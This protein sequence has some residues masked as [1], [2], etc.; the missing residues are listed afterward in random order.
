MNILISRNNRVKFPPQ[1]LYNSLSLSLLSFHPFILNFHSF[2][3][4]PFKTVSTRIFQDLSLLMV[5]LHD[6][7]PLKN[8][9]IRT[10]YYDI[11]FVVKGLSYFIHSSLNFDR[12]N[13]HEDRWKLIASFQTSLILSIQFVIHNWIVIS[14]DGTHAKE[15]SIPSSNN[16]L[17]RIFY[18]GSIYPN[19]TNYQNYDTPSLI[20]DT[21][22]YNPNT[23]THRI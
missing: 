22:V 11:Q 1:F 18:F 12:V 9:S 5:K 8:D 15:K 3:S 17:E 10:M 23:H 2:H 4:R 13:N 20:S 16:C 19:K 14:R 21:R 7:H 6:I